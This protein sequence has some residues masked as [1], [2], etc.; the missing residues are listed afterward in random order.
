MKSRASCLNTA[1]IRENFKR[2][3]PITAVATVFWFLSG[4]FMMMLPALSGVSGDIPHLSYTAYDVIFKH[5]SAGSILLNLALP[6]ALSVACFGYLHKSSSSNVMHAVPVTRTSLYLSNYLSG[7]V[8]SLIPMIINA[9]LVPLALLA[10]ANINMGAA[11]LLQFMLEEF[12][13]IF[14]VYALSVFAAMVSGNGVIHALT[15]IAFN[16]LA[17]VMYLLY[18]FHASMNYF[19]YSTGSSERDLVMMLSPYSY[20]LETEPFTAADLAGYSIF[21]L[22][23]SALGLAVYKIRRLE[24]AGDSYV[25]NAA[26]YIIGFLFCFIASSITA[27]LF[28]NIGVFSYVIGF[29]IGYI[30]GQMIVNKTTKIFNAQSLKAGVV[31]ALAIVLL[32]GAVK[33][34][35]FGYEKRVPQASSVKNARLYSWTVVNYSADAGD[36]SFKKPE[37]IALLTA[38]HQ[39]IVNN[40]DNFKS[41]ESRYQSFG[42]ER[43]EWVTIEY[44]LGGRLHMGRE[45]RVNAGFLR[46]SEAL[47]ALWECDESVAARNFVANFAPENCEIFLGTRPFAS[48]YG[49]KDLWY[50][51]I[52]SGADD[53]RAIRG[54]MEALRKDIDNFEFSDLFDD[55]SERIIDL[56]ISIRASRA[57]YEKAKAE[58]DSPETFDNYND[59]ARM[60]SHYINISLDSRFESTIKYIRDLNLSEDWNKTLDLM[61]KN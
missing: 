61:F 45:Y 54:L 1:I 2:F 60:N 26:R 12:V 18:S 21:A 51:F 6:V 44:E 39:E 11:A 55:P 58:S 41:S 38:F 10:R 17:H 4:P 46:R 19:G 28:G 5:I 20:M 23:V 36:F 34:D 7:L 50:E 25:F 29:V 43:T 16:F 3:W 37:N 59:Y 53:V 14:F 32:V 48:T 57:D 33:L 35:V 31:Y 40:K 56:S 24:R 52:P 13:I 15:A 9:P 47:K 49:D 30:F 27:A 8:M 42:N 22:L